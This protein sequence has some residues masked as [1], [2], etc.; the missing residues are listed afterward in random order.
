MVPGAEPDHVLQAVCLSMCLD[1]ED[2]R[3]KTCLVSYTHIQGAA[4]GSGRTGLRTEFG[5]CVWTLS[6]SFSLCKSGPRVPD[7]QG[8]CEGDR[9]WNTESS[10]TPLCLSGMSQ[11]PAFALTWLLGPTSCPKVSLSLPHHRA[12]AG[13]PEQLR[14]FTFLGEKIEGLE[15]LNGVLASA[16]H[17]LKLEPYRES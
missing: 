11:G 8:C 14:V 15:S 17:R 10:R 5:S 16:A 9:K 6:P 12:W 3:L 4:Q 1:G 7:R 2:N 13:L